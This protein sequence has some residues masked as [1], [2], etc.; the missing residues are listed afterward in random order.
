MR[1]RVLFFSLL[2]VNLALGIAWLVSA[3]RHGPAPA[4]PEVPGTVSG[5]IRTNVV[6]RRQFFSWR[7]VESADYPTYITNLRDIGCPEQTIRDIIIADVNALY[8]RKLATEVTTPEQQWWRSKP[9]PAI[10]RAA[11]DKVRALNEERRA[12]LTRLLGPNWESG[13]LASLPRPSRPGIILDGPVLG[14]LPAEAKQAVQDISARAQS[15]L[16]DYLESQRLL[17]KPAD[18]VELARLRQQTRD[19]LARALTP[20]QLEEYLLRYSQNANNL[21]A[22]LGRLKFFDASPEEFRGLF[23]ATDSIDQQ[24]E[25]LAGNN[26]PNAVAQRNALLQ[27]RDS[28]VKLALG[29]DRYQQYQ[30]FQD[31]LYRDAYATAQ[32]SGDTGAVATLYQINLAAAQQQAAIRADTNLTEEQRAIELKRVELEQLQ[33]NAQAMGQETSSEAPPAQPPA[34]NEPVALAP[35]THR[36]VLGAGESAASIAM[37]YGLSLSALKAANPDLDLRRLKPG[38]AIRIPGPGLTA[39]NSP[40]PQ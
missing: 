2:G 25:L 12:L 27:Q 37:Q 19:D 21:R 28:A 35:P 22:D 26:D 13:D 24:L 40:P 20:P 39:P 14:V 4:I 30:Q 23:R 32:K 7:E 1:W 18:P 17:G 16:E 34:G 31:P 33:A 11:A 5:V 9:D 36:Y 8:A 6:V 3:R 29:A 38:D 15:R 10:V